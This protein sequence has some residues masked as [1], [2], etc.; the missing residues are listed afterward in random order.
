MFSTARLTHWDS[1]VAH[2]CDGK[3]REP[4]RDAEGIHTHSSD[5]DSSNIPAKM[6]VMLDLPASSTELCMGDPESLEI[7]TDVQSIANG[8]K[9][10]ENVSEYLQMTIKPHTHLGEV[11]DYAQRTRRVSSHPLRPHTQGLNVS[12]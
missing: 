8:S 7:Q 3:T 6:S 11:Q 2:R 10:A 12:Q 1:N 4:R 9:M 5:L